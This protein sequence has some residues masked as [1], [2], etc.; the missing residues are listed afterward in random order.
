MLLLA[1]FMN[2]LNE[3]LPYLNCAVLKPFWQWV[4][5]MET[6]EKCR[7]IGQYSS[8]VFMLSVEK[9][10]LATLLW[11]WLQLGLQEIGLDPR[12]RFISSN[13]TSSSKERKKK[14]IT[15]LPSLA[16]AVAIFG[17]HFMRGPHP[18]FGLNGQL[19]S[20]V[21]GTNAVDSQLNSKWT[22]GFRP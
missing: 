22:W 5:Q 20:W 12:T 21:Q 10:L 15:V 16:V 3:S 11:C 8:L 17:V 19:H 4:E 7:K 14:K 2:A 6:L 9:K 1:S 13:S 18:S